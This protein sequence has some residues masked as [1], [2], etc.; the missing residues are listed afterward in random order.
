[1]LIMSDDSNDISDECHRTLRLLEMLKRTHYELV[2]VAI[3]KLF[4]L[5]R[6]FFS[7]LLNEHPG[8]FPLYQI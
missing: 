4:D 2:Q 8:K 7:Y 1:M 3:N 6:A 5:I